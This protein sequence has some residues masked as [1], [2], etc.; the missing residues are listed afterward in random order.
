MLRLSLCTKYLS[1][2]IVQEDTV[3]VAAAAAAAVAVTSP[4]QQPAALRQTA[5]SNSNSSS[6][7]KH[8]HHHRRRAPLPVKAARLVYRMMLGAT[9]LSRRQ[10]RRRA[11]KLAS[12][13]SGDAATDGATPAEVYMHENIAITLSYTCYTA[14]V[15]HLLL[16]ML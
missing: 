6:S 15:F 3:K 14:V 1:N 11:M 4:S 16:C 8:A 5:R 13:S 2:V 7:S 12:G 9:F 10:Q